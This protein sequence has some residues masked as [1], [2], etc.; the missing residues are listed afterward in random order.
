[1]LADAAGRRRRHD[2]HRLPRLDRGGGC[3][4]AGRAAPRRLRAGPDH[5]PRAQGAWR[6]RG[7]RA[8]GRLGGPVGDRGRDPAVPPRRGGRR[9]ADR[10]A[11][12][13]QRC[14]RPRRGLRRGRGH[15]DQRRRLQ[16][17]AVGPRGAEGLGAPD[18]RGPGRR[19]RLHVGARASSRGSV[20]RS[21]DDLV[22]IRR[23]NL[24]GRLVLATVGPITA[25]PL[26]DVGM[27]PLVPGRWRLGAVVRELVTHYAELPV[28]RD[29]RRRAVGARAGGRARR[30][31]A[32][33]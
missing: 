33:R 31:G 1:M 9:A 18:G 30:P 6:D 4:G 29:R 21:A 8:H 3:R 24:A 15:R 27:V 10:G 7:R 2:G 12:P 26:T 13:R 19:G 5:R 11:A 28:A 23:R 22:A 32:S 14:R 16:L 17:G 20:P 25:A